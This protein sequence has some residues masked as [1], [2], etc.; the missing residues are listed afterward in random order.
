MAERDEA[1]KLLV[2]TNYKSISLKN[3]TYMIIFIK[4][5]WNCP[6]NYFPKRQDNFIGSGK[7]NLI[8][9]L[10]TTCHLLVRWR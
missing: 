8:N 3:I 6:I 9:E 1:T 2:N 7:Q 4:K 5:L 10:I